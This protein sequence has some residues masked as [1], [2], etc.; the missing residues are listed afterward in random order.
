M[1]LEKIIDE[2]IKIEELEEVPIIYI[3]KVATELLKLLD[4]YE[5]IKI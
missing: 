1:E 5:Y 2:L 3:L 4:K